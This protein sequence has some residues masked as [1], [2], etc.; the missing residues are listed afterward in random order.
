MM[1]LIDNEMI[2]ECAGNINGRAV[3]VWGAGQDAPNIVGKLAANG[4]NID[5]FF[6]QKYECQRTFLGKPVLAP[7][8]WKKESHYVFIG[9]SRFQTEIK[10]LLLDNGGR[11]D[12]L[13]FCPS[14]KTGNHSGRINQ[15][16]KK[17][18][19]IPDFGDQY[20]E[21][22]GNY[23][24][25]NITALC[26][27]NGLHNTTGIMADPYSF[28]GILGKEK[29]TELCSAPAH[30]NPM[31]KLIIGNDVWI[32]AYAYINP[33]S[34]RHI[35]DGAV[36]GAGAVVTRDVPPYA[37]VAG[38]PAR[39]IKYRYSPDEI[40]CLLRVRWWDWTDD[41]IRERM[42]LLFTPKLFFEK[43]MQ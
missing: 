40:E 16:I 33:S 38:V 35:G 19:N 15:L 27:G 25:I 29:Y 5:L 30:K 4:V 12:K 42:E 17:I 31:E 26:W 6:D 8:S 11:G 22:I 43:Y 2:R 9:T 7:S 1:M 14:F 13:D 23:T 24:T 3:A 36:V 32:G 18:L 39:I 21:S 34:V 28:E 41:E 10:R 37:V 20:V